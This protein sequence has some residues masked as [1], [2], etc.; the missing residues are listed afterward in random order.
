MLLGLLHDFRPGLSGTFEDEINF[1]KWNPSWNEFNIKIVEDFHTWWARRPMLSEAGESITARLASEFRAYSNKFILK[2][3]ETSNFILNNA[4]SCFRLYAGWFLTEYI[5]NWSFFDHRKM[6]WRCCSDKTL[7]SYPM[8]NYSMITGWLT[9]R[10]VMQTTLLERH[11]TRKWV[12]RNTDYRRN[13][14]S[15]FLVS[16]LHNKRG[17]KKL[18]ELPRTSNNVV[19]L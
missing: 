18:L 14:S 8:S 5:V 6:S 9:T 4:I 2:W 19:I 10:Q 7:H 15:I 17:A 16:E 12:I 1:K 11:S 13:L 3:F